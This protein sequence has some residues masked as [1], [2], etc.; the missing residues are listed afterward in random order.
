MGVDAFGDWSVVL[1]MRI[2]TVPLKQWDVGREL[3]KRIRKRFEDEGIEIPFPERVVTVRDDK[4]KG[5][6]PSA[7]ASAADD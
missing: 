2:K 7:S 1:K 6:G 5:S 3:R 4:D